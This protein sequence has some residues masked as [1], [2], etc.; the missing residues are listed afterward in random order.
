VSCDF[1]KDEA[2]VCDTAAAGRNGNALRG[3]F[4]QAMVRLFFVQLRIAHPGNEG[5][6][7]QHP[8]RRRRGSTR[9]LRLVVGALS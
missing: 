7:H 5:R 2:D 8:H 6:G 9:L 1:T 4:D 3:E